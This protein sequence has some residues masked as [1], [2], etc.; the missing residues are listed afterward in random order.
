MTVNW[1]MIAPSPP[2]QVLPQIDVAG[3]FFKGQAAG[4]AKRQADRQDEAF[5][6]DRDQKIAT[7]FGMADTPAA[8][9]A[10]LRALGQRGYE[11]PEPFR[12]FEGARAAAQSWAGPQLLDLQHRRAQI[13]M[14]GAQMAQMRLQTPEAREAMARRFGLTPGTPDFNF[15]VLNGQL[16]QQRNPLLQL[17][18]PP[19]PQGGGPPAQAPAAAADAPLATGARMAFA[20]GATGAAVM[21]APGAAP[22]RAGTTVGGGQPAAA[23]GR[24]AIAR[25]SAGELAARADRAALAAGADQA[26][27]RRLGQQP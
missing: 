13:D 23:T 11:I 4:L 17:L 25:R 15:F 21:P 12:T 16:P 10:V 14:M 9:A 26:L 6:W 7:L 1:G 27:H 5:E 3:S 24:V 22:L 18:Q 8:H 2:Q 20:P 19:S